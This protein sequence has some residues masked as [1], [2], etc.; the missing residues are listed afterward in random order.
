M[1]YR[2]FKLFCIYYFNWPKISNVGDFS[3]V[4]FLGIALNFRRRK[5]IR[6]R[7]FTSSIKR[8]NRRHVVVVQVRQCYKN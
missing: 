4:D 5:K 1:N 6:R 7:L 2:F 8:E 3:E